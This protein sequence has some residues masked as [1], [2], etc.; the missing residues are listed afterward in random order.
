VTTHTKRGNE[1]GKGKKIVWKKEL[2]AAAVGLDSGGGSGG[3]LSCS[4]VGSLLDGKDR[5]DDRQ[6]PESS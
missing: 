3:E 5:L 6:A 1:K 4:A 2:T